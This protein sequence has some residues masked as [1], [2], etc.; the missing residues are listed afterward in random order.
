MPTQPTQPPHTTEEM[1]MIATDQYADTAGWS[2]S[3]LAFLALREDVLARWEREVRARVAGAN[4]LLHP[5][6]INTLPA[7]YGNIAESL[8]PAN[9]RMLATSD[10]DSASAHGSE[11]ARMTAFGPD[12]V[13]Q[14]YQILRE[15][16]V[17]ETAG[18]VELSPLEW[19]AIDNSI[20]SAVVEAVRNFMTIH[21]ELRKRVAAS[22][23]HDMRTPLAV[24]TTGA[25]VIGL[26]SDLE[27]AKRGALKIAANAQRLSQMVDDLLDALTGRAGPEL[28]LPLSCFDIEA[29]VCAV[30]DEFNEDGVGQYQAD[31]VPVQGYWCETA[32]RRALENLLGNAHKYGDGGSIRTSIRQTHQRVVLSVHNSGAPIAQ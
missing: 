25:D 10:T 22:L 28:A 8:S 1:P 5:V 19:A 9:P 20:N 30:V 14:E 16:I 6:L 7:F 23:S 4:A 21:D 26:A 12:Q 29:L 11:R 32:L 18:R 31:T 27:V 13:I 2:A 17:A 24:I 3:A 15:A